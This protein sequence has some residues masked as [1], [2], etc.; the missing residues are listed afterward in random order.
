MAV[1]VPCIGKVHPACG[2]NRPKAEKTKRL[3][4]YAHCMQRYALATRNSQVRD[5][6]LARSCPKVKSLQSPQSTEQYN[7]Q[8]PPTPLPPPPH[9]RAYAR[10]CKR[11]DSHE[12]STVD[13]KSLGKF[14]FK[15]V[16]D[17]AEL[18]RNEDKMKATLCFGILSVV[19]KI[20]NCKHT[21]NNSKVYD[22][23]LIKTTVGERDLPVV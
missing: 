10:L 8:S 7:V 20:V 19:S 1:G 18:I 4:R 11:I 17:N 12:Y 22:E 16:E 9:R 14:Q 15:K 23:V 6:E 13:T 5:R 2:W 21:I 3:F